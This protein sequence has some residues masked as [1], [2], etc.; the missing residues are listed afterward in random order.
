[1][2]DEASK[3]E[4]T[5]SRLQAEVASLRERLIKAEKNNRN[6]AESKHNED[7][8]AKDLERA[9][10]EAK[11]EN[12][13]RVAETSQFQQMR[14]MMQSQS[15]KIRDLRKRLQKYEPDACKEDDDDL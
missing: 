5:N 1:M 9:L 14:K 7:V 11:E 2:R 8:Q 12:S 10:E 13:K 3:L 4:E 6:L 15:A